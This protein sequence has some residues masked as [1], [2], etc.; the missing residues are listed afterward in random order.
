[1]ETRDQFL[2]YSEEMEEEKEEKEEDVLDKVERKNLL[3]IY[4]SIQK[5]YS[6]IKL[7]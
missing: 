2:S 7:D 1:M 6:I 5:M 4:T 3:M